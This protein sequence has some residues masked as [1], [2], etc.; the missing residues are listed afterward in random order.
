MNSP[1][2]ICIFG[3]LYSGDEIG[4]LCKAKID[5]SEIS[6]W[7]KDI[8]SFI[9]LWFNDKDII[10][11]TTSGSTGTPSKIKL[12]KE[13]MISSAKATI[14]YFNL[15]EGDSVWLCLPSKYIAAKIMI[16]RAIAGKLNL[17]YSKPT[18]EPKLPGPDISFTAMV[19]NQVSS[20][21]NTPSG[22]EI[23]RSAGKLLIG[24]SAISSQLENKLKEKGLEAWHSYG[25]T[26]TIT[27]IAMRKIGRD[28]TF[29]LLPGVS[30]S[31]NSN[32]QLVVDAIDRGVENL[33]TNDLC[34][35]EKDGS[36]IITGRL[37]NVIISGGIKV[38]AEKVEEELA[39]ITNNFYFV[40][41][42][43]DKLMGEKVVLF[44]EGEDKNLN[45]D[46]IQMKTQNSLS[47]YE[48]P[49]EIVVIDRFQRTESGKIK[50]KTT[51][52]K[53]IKP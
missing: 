50:R 32:N 24:G 30:V 42:I 17:T 22:I 51:I 6:P 41:G 26:E 8:F 45:I 25:M 1:Y 49:K 16:I 15:N 23:L 3:K 35:I 2:Q 11:V 53:Y 28:S 7:E 12:S 34:K 18:T 20:L 47:R 43:P 39:G 29:Q 52:E 19:P 33:V 40:G 9:E 36:F 4:Y 46:L 21:L 5:S 14:D 10:T 27:H 44:I 38:H 48:I 31:Q 37:D 13:H